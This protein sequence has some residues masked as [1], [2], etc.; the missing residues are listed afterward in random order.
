MPASPKWSCG[1]AIVVKFG[2]AYEPQPLPKGFRKPPLF[3]H[4][5]GRE[6]MRVNIEDIK[7]L[8]VQK[9]SNIRAEVVVQIG[10]SKVVIEGTP[11][12]F[13]EVVKSLNQ[14]LDG[15]FQNRGDGRPG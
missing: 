8:K 5:K 14:S 6:P 11:E 10:D 4:R 12:E 1:E 13:R 7:S 9:V 2:Q 3:I 15:L